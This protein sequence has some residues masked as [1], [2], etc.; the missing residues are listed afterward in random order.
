MWVR[1]EIALERENVDLEKRSATN[2]AQLPEHLKPL[3]P[4]KGTVFSSF[5]SA[6][7]DDLKCS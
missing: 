3:L 5:S 7:E 1:K 4:R 2:F 6:Q